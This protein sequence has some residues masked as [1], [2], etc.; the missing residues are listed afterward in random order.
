MCWFQQILLLWSIIDKNVFLLPGEANIYFRLCRD[1]V[2][3]IERTRLYVCITSFVI[4]CDFTQVI[5]YSAR[6]KYPVL[7]Y[8]FL[9]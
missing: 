2:I 1:K 3:A 4:V 6:K 5:R 9:K 7:V 8:H